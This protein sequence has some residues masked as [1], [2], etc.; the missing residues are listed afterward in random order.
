MRSQ[1]RIPPLPGYYSSSSLSSLS[2]NRTS[3]FSSSSSSSVFPCHEERRH[4]RRR[5]HSFS[6]TSVEWMPRDNGVFVSAGL[7]PYVKVRRW[8]YNTIPI[9]STDPYT[10]AIKLFLF[11]FFFLSP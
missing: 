8:E 10:I 4:L 3:L 11:F 7:E 6:V 1:N 2:H 5:G 9:M